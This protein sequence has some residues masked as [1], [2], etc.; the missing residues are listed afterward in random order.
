MK[1]ALII[2]E[3]R[4]FR[5]TVVSWLRRSDWCVLEA[6]DAATGLELSTHQAP[7]LVLCDLS[8]PGGCGSQ[9]FHDFRRR[10]PSPDPCLLVALGNGRA[11]DRFQALEAGADEYLGRPV[12][13]ERLAAILSRHTGEPSAPGPAAGGGPSAPPG[14][15]L[16]FW[17]V[18]GSIPTPGTDT[19]W[20]G[21]NTSCVEVRAGT[22]IIILDS[23]SGIRPLGQALMAEFRGRP[24][25]LSLLITHA[26]WD[27]IQGFPFFLPAYDPRNQVTIFGFE[28]ARQ[29]LQNT[30]S[31]QMESPYF[32]ISLQQMPGHISFQ[33]VQ[34]LAFQV[35]AVPVQAQFLNHPGVCT[36]YRLNTPGGDISYLPDV[37]LFQRLRSTAEIDTAHLQSQERLFAG[38]QDRKVLEFIRGS[39][40]LILDAQYNAAEYLTHVG[41][42]HSCAEDSVAFAL[43][44][45]VKRLFLFHH[46]PDHNDEEIS[47]MVA[48]AREMTA[49]RGSS[50]IVEAAREG[51]ELVLDPLASK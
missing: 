4:D 48:R 19:V 42:G 29:G 51:F 37:E 41:W 2:N 24:I 1:S 10:Q 30:L 7:Q 9:F 44:A 46:D 31:S 40:V 20:Y 26:H 16:K 45:N 36:G 23:G 17:G 35:G 28:G 11:A 25:H 47:R 34:G 33:E 21:G 22:E 5:Q 39:E 12:D 32:P 18:R 38:E 3:D 14:A 15:R 13:F 43:Q 6:G 8:S 27:H 50:L 49:N